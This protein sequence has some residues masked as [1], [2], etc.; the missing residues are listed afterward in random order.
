MGNQFWEGSQV[1]DGGVPRWIR[2]EFGQKLPNMSTGLPNISENCNFIEI[3]LKFDNFW[4][5][6]ILN[7]PMWY[8][9][10]LYLYKNKLNHLKPGLT[11][12]C[13]TSYEWG[14]VK[15]RVLSCF[16]L[17]IL[18]SADSK[19]GWFRSKITKFNHSG[20]QKV[21]NDFTPS[22]S[23]PTKILIVDGLFSAIMLRLASAI[24]FRL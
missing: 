22:F 1:G 9:I 23:F 15:F 3:R 2:R 4:V 13:V 17:I 10:Y 11:L 20:Y 21:Q 14:A 16:W 5:E 18:V 6:N 12:I 8:C 24:V 7:K 19:S